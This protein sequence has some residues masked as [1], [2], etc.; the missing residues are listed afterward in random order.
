MLVSLL[1]PSSVVRESY[2]LLVSALTH[3][4]AVADLGLYYVV[5]LA[6]MLV[7]VVLAVARSYAKYVN[8]L[9][10]CIKVEHPTCLL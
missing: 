8:N 9:V 5:D 2:I 1:V 10:T 7:L 3:T 4:I 6:V